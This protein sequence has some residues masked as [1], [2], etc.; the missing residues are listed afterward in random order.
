MNGILNL[1]CE[2][3]LDRLPPARFIFMDPPDNLGLEYDEYVDNRPSQD[4]YNWLDLVMHKAVRLTPI[5]MISYYWQHD[6]EIKYLARNLL[7]FRHPSYR[8]KTFLWRYTF[9]QHV[10][11]D[12][13]S[14]FRYLLRLQRL[15]TQ[16]SADSIRVQSWR[17]ANGDPRACPDGRVPDD[18][19]DIPRVTGNSAER[20]S[21][22]PTQHPEALI[23]RLLL[24]HT[25]PG[26]QVID[27]CGGTGTVQRVAARLNR[28][29]VTVELSRHYANQISEETHVPILQI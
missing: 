25:S 4:Y 12:C 1:P 18:V 15:G 16:L 20:R 13:G 8:A 6:L 7:K 2:E 10:Q 19:W 5:F 29:C 17:Q 3:A 21:W 28:E 26:E 23:E 22:H 14:G 27:L 9:G 11:T 24:L